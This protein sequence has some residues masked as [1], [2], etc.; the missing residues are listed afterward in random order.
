MA[1]GPAY[2]YVTAA[3][4]NVGTA[5]ETTLILADK[6]EVFV[7]VSFHYVRS[8]GTAAT[9]TPRLGQ[10]AS[11]TND[12]INERMTYASTAVAVATNEVF[13]S[14]IPC[15]TDSNGYLY[16]RPGFNAGADNDGNFEFVFA[17]GL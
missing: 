11:W 8:G 7:L 17:K 13:T 15:K 6:S 9:Y 2:L 5:E 16:F 3:H 14:P 12:D 4:L 10:A 1:R